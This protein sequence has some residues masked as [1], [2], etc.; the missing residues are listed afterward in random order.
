MDTAASVQADEVTKANEVFELLQSWG[1]GMQWYHVVSAWGVKEVD[2][3][4]WLPDNVMTEAGASLI[5]KRRWAKGM[6]DLR[7][8]RGAPAASS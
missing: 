1:L 8:I 6:A 5:E 3:L 4:L 7:M 2:D